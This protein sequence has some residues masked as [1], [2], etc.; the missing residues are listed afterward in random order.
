MYTVFSLKDMITYWLRDQLYKDT[1]HLIQ[2]IDEKEGV[3]VIVN[4][5]GLAK[6]WGNYS[7]GNSNLDK[8]NMA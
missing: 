5:Q 7:R 6:A 3:F 4:P 2:W 8:D 1:G